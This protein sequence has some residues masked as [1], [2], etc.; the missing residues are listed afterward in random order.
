MPPLREQT[1]DYYYDFAKDGG[2]VGNVNLRGPALPS[3]AIVTDAL[4]HVD[5]PLGS[6]GGATV[7]VGVESTTDVQAAAAVSGAP[8]SSGGPKRGSALTASATPVKT[9]ARRQPRLTVASAA[10]N[11]GKLRVRLT[12]VK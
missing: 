5:T 1:A 9:T 12:Y 2:A 11:A 3:G 10:L 8:W 7:A 4:V 6:G